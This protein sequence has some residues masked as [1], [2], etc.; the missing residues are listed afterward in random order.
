MERAAAQPCPAP[1]PEAPPSQRVEGATWRA[2]AWV[3]GT[4]SW[5]WLPGGWV[6]PTDVHPAV[7][8]KR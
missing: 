7:P 4:L 6:R 8:V 1:R 3:W 2:G 5:V